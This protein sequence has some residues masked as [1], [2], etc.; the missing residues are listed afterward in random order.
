M[1]K[2]QAINDFI[3]F[4][5]DPNYINRISDYQIKKI[6]KEVNHNVLKKLNSTKYKKIINGNNGEIFEK[7]CELQE[8]DVNVLECFKFDELTKDQFKKCLQV[9]LNSNNKVEKDYLEKKNV[10]DKILYEV[11][12]DRLDKLKHT[13]EIG[14]LTSSQKVKDYLATSIKE[15]GKN[16]IFIENAN[17]IID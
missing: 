11:D 10:L 6:I 4:L 16:H 15:G 17:I 7:L 12:P 3:N 1:I 14:D 9:L 5:K 13:K 8:K 2:I